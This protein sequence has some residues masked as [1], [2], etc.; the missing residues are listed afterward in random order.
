MKSNT[1][2][3]MVPTRGRPVLLERYAKSVA[4]TAND[5]SRIEIHAYIDKDDP[6]LDEYLATIE[7]LSAELEVLGLTFAGV[8]GEPIG[9]PGA[10]NELGRVSTSDILVMSN[11]DQ[12]YTTFGWDDRI[13]REAVKFPDGIFLFWFADNIDSD[14]W[15]CFPIVGRRWIE[16]LNYYAPT[17]F[18][19]FFVDTWLWDI[20]LRIGRAHYLPDVKVEHIAAWAGLA[21]E[22]DTARRTR[23]PLSAGWLERDR[24]SYHTF[25]RYREIDAQ[26]LRGLLEPSAYERSDGHPVGMPRDKPSR[27]PESQTIHFHFQPNSFSYPQPV[28]ELLD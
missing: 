15:C 26:L 4:Q 2:G 11:D 27:D 19:H 12:I 25:G 13:D 8:V 9:V 20:A 3:L 1:I 16:C 17:M 6:A 28:Q 22:D 18:D 23:G 5:P 24:L 7:W 21:P 10:M 14:R